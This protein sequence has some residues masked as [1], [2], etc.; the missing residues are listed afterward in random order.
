VFFVKE[1][2]RSDKLGGDGTNPA[3]RVLL[4]IRHGRRSMSSE[5]EDM[6]YGL[7]IATEERS[8]RRMARPACSWWQRAFIR[9]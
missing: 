3:D 2:S 7:T 9:L 6:L 8:R 4:G 1:G 5:E